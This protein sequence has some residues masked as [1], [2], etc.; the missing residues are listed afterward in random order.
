MKLNNEFAWYL[1]NQDNLLKDY[2]GKVL[3]IKNEEIIGVFE[4]YGKAYFQISKE[5]KL[6]TFLLQKCS[7]GKDDYT[8]T[9]KA[10]ILDKRS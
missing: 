3:A 6:G 4:D 1:K 5:H 9:F 8:R 7:P 2:N 10:R